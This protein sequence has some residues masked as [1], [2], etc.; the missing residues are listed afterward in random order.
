MYAQKRNLGQ[1]SDSDSWQDKLNM[2][3]AQASSGYEKLKS[4][5]GVADW[6]DQKNFRASS[7]YGK[8]TVTIAMMQRPKDSQFYGLFSTAGR[9][10]AKLAPGTYFKVIASS[11]GRS[12]FGGQNTDGMLVNTGNKMGYIYTKQMIP[13]TPQEF[14][15]KKLPDGS[16]RPQPK[17]KPKPKTAGSALPL[18]AGG[19]VLY[20]LLK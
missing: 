18:V 17:P 6:K 12:N 11:S 10:I 14:A 15:Q 5:V 13:V 3:D 9:E 19:A 8:S 2:W 7:G 20:F 1:V 4:L 16:G